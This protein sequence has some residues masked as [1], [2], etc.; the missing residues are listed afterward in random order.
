MD[1]ALQQLR[2]RLAA[3]ERETTRL[4]KDIAAK[5]E[6]LSAKD[7]EIAAKDQRIKLLERA[8][9]GPRSE[10]VIATDEQQAEFAELL[11][12]LEEPTQDT[13]PEAP[14]EKPV[15][16]PKR[17]KSPPTNIWDLVPENLPVE[18][19]YIDVP[20]QDRIDLETGEPLK[21]IGE[22]RTR[23]LAYRPGSYYKRELVRQKY[24]S[25]KHPEQGVIQAPM[26]ERAI[27]GS[28]FDETF[29]AGIV[30][31]KT[32]MHVPLYRTEEQLHHDGI[33]ISRQTLSRLYMQTAEVLRPVYDELAKEILKSTILFTDDTPV[34]MQK[35]G[36][37]K[38]QTARMWVYCRGGPGERLRLFQFTTDR[39][40]CHPQN[41]LRTFQGYLHADAYAGYNAVF[42][43][44]SITECACWMH[45]RRKFHEAEDAPT[46]LRE[47]IIND[48]RW[49]YLYERLITKKATDMRQAEAEALALH[50]RKDKIAPRIERILSR[51]QHAIRDR[52]VLPKSK[53]AAAI[54]YLQ[55]RGDAL[56]NFLSHPHLEPDN[57]E[58]E[59]AIRPLAIGRKNWLFVGSPRGGEAT[60][61]LLS[62]VQNCRLLGIDPFT[63]LVDVLRR[64]RGT[65]ANAIAELLPH[66]WTPAT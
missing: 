30:V 26:P 31:A 54:G 40:M 15:A 12:E 13:E 8:L 23:Q 35:K 7:Q 36:K 39:R 16:R 2:D 37:G 57:G 38:T 49:L 4:R 24:A 21:K 58:S 33:R 17:K 44:D 28:D 18:E 11:A 32:A 1:T 59:R 48:I 22:D 42:A 9:F 29:I 53:F 10:R 20:E 61:I 19:I 62:L 51:C 55:N 65:P 6:T 27:P 52:Q 64:V 3:S 25:P 45:V 34:K 63:Y 14:A 60:A 50:I 5:E 41:F 46:E 66:R 43:K 56:K 47:E